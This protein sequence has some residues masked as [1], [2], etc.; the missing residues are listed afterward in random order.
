MVNVQTLSER[1]NLHVYLERKADLAVRGE[2]S[3]EKRLSEAEAEMEIRNSDI[4]LYE[5]THQE[6]E[7]QR[8]QLQHA[9]QWVDQSSR[10][11][12]DLCGELEM[13]S[14]LFRE[15]HAKECQEIEEFVAKK[16]IELDKRD[17]MNCLCIK[18][19]TPTT[20]SQL[21]TQIQEQNKV[22]CQ[23]R[24][25]TILRQR[26]ALERPNVPSQPLTIPSPRTMLCRDSGRMTHGTLWVLQ[27]TFFKYL[28]EKDHPQLSSR[29]HGIWH[30][31]HAD[32]DQVMPERSWNVED[33]RDESCT[34][35][36]YLYHASKEEVESFITLVKLILTV[37]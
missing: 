4:A 8:L 34:I 9:N 21:L 20:V 11:K 10:E 13:R 24:V 29:I 15:N 23:M 7:S 31:L 32:W 18:R 19:G 3:A 33:E 12:T 1:P 30:H 14:G 5:T 22:L 36:Q 25:I 17:S 27:E 37:A 35:R 16:Q 6:L 28:L 2:R 26:A